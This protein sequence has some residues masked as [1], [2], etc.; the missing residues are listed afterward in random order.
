MNGSVHKTL[1][2]SESGSCF[3]FQQK[4]QIKRL[5]TP[6]LNALMLRTQFSHAVLCDLLNRKRIMGLSA[7]LGMSYRDT[8]VR[9]L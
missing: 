5:K 9:I 1:A 2:G 6:V 7:L 4:K 3:A 8:R